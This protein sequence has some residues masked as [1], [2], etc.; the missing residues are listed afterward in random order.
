MME[1]IINGLS[2]KAEGASELEEGTVCRAVTADGKLLAIG[3]IQAQAFQPN[4]VF[5]CGE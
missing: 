5:K 2:Q 4:K 1:R 3:T